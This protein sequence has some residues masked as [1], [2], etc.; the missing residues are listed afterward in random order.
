[1]VFIY[2]LLVPPT[3]REKKAHHGLDIKTKVQKEQDK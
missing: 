1:M 3:T 2:N